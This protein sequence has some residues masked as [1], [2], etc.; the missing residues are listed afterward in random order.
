MSN[1]AT[2][3]PLIFRHPSK[4]VSGDVG[5]D[6]WD[7]IHE[8]RVIGRLFNA[9]AGVPPDQPWMWTVNGTI[10]KPLPS[11]GFCASLGRGEMAPLASKWLD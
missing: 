11:Y 3:G 5:P 2:L 9:R 6:D 4:R 1:D 10:V 7:V 8:A